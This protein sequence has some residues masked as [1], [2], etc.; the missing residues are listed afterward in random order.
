MKTNLSEEALT[1]L[2]LMSIAASLNSAI[3]VDFVLKKIGQAAEK[4]L[5]SEAS[6]I[7][8]ATKDRRHLYFKVASGEKGKALETLTLPVGKGIGGHVAKTRET[9]VVNDVKADPRFASEFDAASGFTTRSLVCVPMSSRGELIGVIEVLNRRS[10]PFGPEHVELL[11]KLA[12]FAAAAIDNAKTSNE[13]KNYFSHSLELLAVATEATMPGMGGHTTRAAKLARAIGRTL[14]IEEYEARMLYYA[15][16]LHDIG[17]IAFNNPE[18]LCDLGIQKVSEEQHPF[19][20]TKMLD[21]IA[22]FEDALPV[23]LHHHERWDGKGYPDKLS[24]E[25]IPLGARIL[26]LV[27]NVEEIRMIGLRGAELY[28]KAL[29]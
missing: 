6:A 19:L 9:A 21:G 28:K 23:I 20:S 5:D 13:Q 12:A 1:A 11:T 24:G 18:F 15:G 16:L 10:G 7:M 14:G 27:E 3:D 2:D 8:L 26:N 25:A 22:M 4:M 29:Q 17:Y